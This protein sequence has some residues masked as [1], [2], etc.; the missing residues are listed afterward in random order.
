MDKDFE[1]LKNGWLKPRE[2]ARYLINDASIKYIIFLMSLLTIASA[3]INSSNNSNIEVNMLWKALLAISIFSPLLGAISFGV[4]AFFM[5]IIG[6]VAKGEGSFKDLFRALI[7]SNIP[8]LLAFPFMLT[9]AIL[10]PES[11]LNEEVVAG[12]PI[13]VVGIITLLISIVW[14]FINMVIA[15]SEAHKFS[16]GKALFTIFVPFI[17]LIVLGVMFLIVLIS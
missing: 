8:L 6:K 4:I 13:E 14:T 7:G 10:E 3:T 11:Y 5:W 1:P 12:S 9:W 17:L 16:I 2:T 15:I